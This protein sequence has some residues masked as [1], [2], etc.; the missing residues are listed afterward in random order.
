MEIN[1][2]LTMLRVVLRYLTLK[3]IIVKVLP[4]NKTV[5]QFVKDENYL[6]FKKFLALFSLNLNRKR[7][8][9]PAEFEVIP[10]IK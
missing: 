3:E 8:D 2:K 6:L 4:L 10:L 5:N 7:C 9:L 1:E